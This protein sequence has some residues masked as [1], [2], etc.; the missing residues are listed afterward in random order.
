[1]NFES[2]KKSLEDYG[3]KTLFYAR[4]NLNLKGFAGKKRA[5]NFSGDYSDGLGFDIIEDA[6]SIAVDFTSKEKYGI[7][8]EWGV[9]GTE[10]NHGSE[11][12]F[13]SKTINDKAVRKYISNPKFRLRKV[14]KNKFGQTVS[15]LVQKSKKNIDKAI[16]PIAKAI[17]E[18]GI[19]PVPA[20]QRGSIRAFDD[21]KE[22]LELALA[23]D[24]KTI[25]ITGL[26]KN[27]IKAK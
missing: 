16:Y 10:V 25:M 1:M 9:N 21:C 20:V 8:L 6:N 5:T 11:F 19:K 22:D 23:Q 17:A 12:S 7:F 18:K 27:G 24:L 14:F 26:S 2:L 13:K 4:G 3:D 15:Q